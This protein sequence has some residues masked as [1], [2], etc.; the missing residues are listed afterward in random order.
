[1]KS[2]WVINIYEGIFDEMFK[3]NLWSWRI[4]WIIIKYEGKILFIM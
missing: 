4:G 2:S 1:M 3:E